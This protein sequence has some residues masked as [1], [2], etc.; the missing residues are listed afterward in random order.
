MKSAGHTHSGGKPTQFSAIRLFSRE[1]AIIVIGSASAI[2]L[3]SQPQHE[4]YCNCFHP[5]VGAIS[6][7]CWY[8]SSPY[9]SIYLSIHPSIYLS[10]Q[11][12]IHLSIY[13]SIHPSIHRSIYSS[14][15]LSI[16]PSIHPYIYQSIYQIF[17]DIK[18]VGVEAPSR[19]EWFITTCAKDQHLIRDH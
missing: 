16:H 18:A 17:W 11:P 15:H 2:Y 6:H 8:S 13:P 14:I 19:M 9:L 4:S 12:S 3:G 1:L 5:F 7:N 10:I